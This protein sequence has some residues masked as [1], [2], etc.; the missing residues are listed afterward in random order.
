MNIDLLTL[1]DL[2]SLKEEI[3]N[4]V[5]SCLQISEQENVWL[6]TSEVKKI[7]GC[8]EGTLVNLRASGML[9]YSKIKGTIYI[10]RSDLSKLFDSHIVA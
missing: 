6:K 8:S 3:I 10:R 2:K 1:N 4:E 5:K 9:P 7:L